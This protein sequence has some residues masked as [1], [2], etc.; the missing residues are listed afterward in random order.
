MKPKL[1][2]AIFLG[3]LIGIAAGLYIGNKIAEQPVNIEKEITME[4]PEPVIEEPV[5]QKRSVKIYFSSIK[6]NEGFL[7]CAK[8]DFVIREIENEDNVAQEIMIQLFK[9]PTEEEKAEGLQTFWI[10]E[11][12]AGTLNRIF[13]KDGTAYLDWNEDES[14][15]T[16][17]AN[18]SCGSQSFLTPIEMTLKALPGVQNVVH[19]INGKPQTFYEWMQMDCG[20]DCDETP[21]I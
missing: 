16:S 2:L 4:E 19:A 10:T 6:D 21:F 18:S 13:I 1:I 8:T 20:E 11:E 14:M 5:G 3:L 12:K 15:L 17:G 7:D 9:G